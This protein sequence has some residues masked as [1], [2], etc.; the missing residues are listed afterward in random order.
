MNSQRANRF[1]RYALAVTM[2]AF[3]GTVRYAGAE[4]KARVLHFPPERSLGML[5]T[6]DEG[7]QRKIKD[8]HYWIDGTEM[9]WDYLGEAMGEV[10]VPTGKRVRLAL[11]MASGNNLSGL[12]QLRSNDLYEL[13]LGERADDGC[14]A[15]V[16]R[17]TGL[18]GLLF[19]RSYTAEGKMPFF[20]QRGLKQL[21]AL[22]S[23]ERLDA[24]D[25]LTDAGLAALVE[26][27]PQL[28]R[29]H[30]G[31]NQLTDAGLAALPRLTALEELTIGGG[32][33]SNGG[34][35]A[36]ARLPA[37]QYLSLWGNLLNDGALVQVRQIASLKT[38]VPTDSI[39][40]D[41]VA[42]LAG[43]AGLE[44]LDLFNTKVTDRGVEHLKSLP[45]LRA[46]NLRKRDF[47]RKN[48]PITDTATAHLKAIPTLEQ[49]SLCADGLTDEGVI[50]LARL[51]RLKHVELPLPQW[52]DPKNYRAYYTEKSIKELARVRS[53]EHL[54]L[55][56]PGVTDA[57]LGHI[58]R[59]ANLRS[60]TLFGCPISDVGL[61]K[62]TALRALEE[63]T[64]MGNSD[65]TI[66]GLNKLNC[67]DRLT[68]LRVH[69]LGQEGTPLQI[70]GLERL[71]YLMISTDK[72]S[73]FH[74]SDLA[75]LANL[76]RLKWVQ[77]G[78]ELGITDAGMANLS[79]LRAIDRL[80]IGGAGLTD[81]SLAVLADMPR[82]DLVTISGDFTDA[83][84]SRLE[85]LKGLRFATIRSANNFSSA[86]KARLRE[87]LPN[88]YQLTADGDRA[89]GNR[90]T[91]SA[92]PKPGTLAPDFTVTTLDAKTFTL[93]R[94][95]GKVV[96]LHFW[97]TWCTPCMKSFPAL[98]AFHDRIKQR[99][100]E[101]VVLLDLATDDSE[102]RVRSAVATHKLTTPQARIGMKSK[103]AASYG[104]EG[105]PD[106]FM[107]GPDG[108]I[109]LNRESP[110]GPGDTEVVIDRAL[111]LKAASRP[112]RVAVRP[113]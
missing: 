105:V 2:V 107:I 93:S 12:A 11:N 61:E 101:K 40:D 29:L 49:V 103:L 21:A 36:L 18:R 56:G 17:L 74:D 13:S 37:L 98:S 60:L 67:L 92:H 78:I 1:A 80:V 43:H 32:R 72:G 10:P 65:V 58:A 110:E 99:Y 24:P 9:K 42:H 3:C 54:S 38:F 89:V 33:I 7:I 44:E 84:L 63:L 82:L 109:L 15:H 86:A 35:A 83:G 22:K 68:N 50:N 41:G 113:R 94:Q 25:Q 87:N 71:E 51:P 39:T 19:P 31:R 77:M 106:D 91:A 79:G 6:L 112:A 104:V 20:S 52:N 75:C 108:K 102:A 88:L 100:G 46:V 70:G 23:L 111:G 53:L 97:A 30:L 47:D 45:S 28:K 66:G 85:G 95:R 90:A 81:R 76:K 14:L 62:L 57:A 34:L 5:F 59:L 55:A 4:T 16:A 26:A 48:P 73:T 27:L 96:L 64:I 8:Y 69:S